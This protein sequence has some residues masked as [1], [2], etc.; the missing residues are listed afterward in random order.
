MNPPRRNKS[1]DLYGGYPVL[2]LMVFDRIAFKSRR[3]RVSKRQDTDDQV[4]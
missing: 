2:L 3:R 1:P 4:L